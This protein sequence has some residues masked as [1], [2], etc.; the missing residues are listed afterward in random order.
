MNSHAE[1]HLMVVSPKLGFPTAGEVRAE[2]EHRRARGGGGW[3][4][5]GKLGRIGGEQWLTTPDV[6]S[7]ELRWQQAPWLAREAYR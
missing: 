4:P 6:N 7:L 1:L 5:C 2:N 3:V